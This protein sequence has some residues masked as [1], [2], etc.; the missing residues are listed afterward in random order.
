LEYEDGRGS[1][2]VRRNMIGVEGDICAWEG[3]S[4]TGMEKT[5]RRGASG[6]VL[7]TRCYLGETIK[8]DELSGHVARRGRREMH[9]EFLWVSVK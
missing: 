4:N 5:V 9:T 3:R 2:I 8:E 7:L 6:V 1:A